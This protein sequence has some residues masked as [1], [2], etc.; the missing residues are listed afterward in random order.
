M[1]DDCTR[2]SEGHLISAGYKEDC[3]IT[4]DTYKEPANIPGIAAAVHSKDLSSDNLL[5]VSSSDSSQTDKNKCQ[6]KHQ[7]AHNEE[8]TF[9]CSEFKKCFTL[10]QNF[11][12]HQRI[13]TG[14]KPYS[15]SEC[16][17][18]FITISKLVTHQ[19]IHTGE[20]PYSCSACDKRFTSKSNLVMHQRIHTG[21]KPF[22]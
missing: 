11:G 3:G 13:H 14:E 12:L 15:C 10:K 6:E 22:S 16:G 5:Q 2:S 20:R 1:T 17:K 18:C 7:R 8:K 19:R 9:P 21:E 4:Q